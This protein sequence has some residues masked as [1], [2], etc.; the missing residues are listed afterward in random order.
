M[1]KKITAVSLVVILVALLAMGTAA[2]T[3][4]EHEDRA[5]NIITT[6][7]IEMMLDE[8]L[9]PLEWIFPDEGQKNVFTLKQ[10]VYPTQIIDKTPTVTN[11]GPEPFYTRVKVEIV[12]TAP[13]GTPL[14][15]EYLLPQFNG[16]GS[17]VYADGWYYYDGVLTPGQESSP[18]FDGVKVSAETP[19]EYGNATVSIVV[20]SQAVQ[21]K[22]N[23]VPE[24][25]ITAVPGWPT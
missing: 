4:Y 1:K 25:G 5:T 10:R 12:V 21:V 6:N 7:K 17:W 13:D 14:S 15:A 2:Y 20:T 18:L 22:N 11:T 19:N 24:E 8:H 9:D 16:D 23:P 3:Y